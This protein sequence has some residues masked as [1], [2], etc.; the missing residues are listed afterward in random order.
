MQVEQRRPLKCNTSFPEVGGGEDR[1]THTHRYLFV[2]VCIIGQRAGFLGLRW[3]GNL[4]RYRQNG[5]HFGILRLIPGYLFFAE[6]G[7][8]NSN[9]QGIVIVGRSL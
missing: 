5:Y 2:V 8:S 4:C 9:S 7:K 1:D 3:A 6:I